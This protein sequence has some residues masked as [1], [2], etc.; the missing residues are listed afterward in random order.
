MIQTNDEKKKQGTELG[1]AGTEG[2]NAE[3]EMNR[4]YS[5]INSRKSFSY[6]PSSDPMYRSYARQYDMNGRMA[7]RNSM[8]QTA[9]LTGGY[10]S[11]YGAAVGQQQYDEYMRRLSDQLPELY[12][13][14]YQRYE[15][16]GKALR[17]NYDMAYQRYETDY[18]R[19][20]DALA[21]QQ[22]QEQQDYARRQDS[23]NNLTKLI[24]TAGY[25]P[26]DSELAGAGMTRAQAD[27]LRNRYLMDKGLLGGGSGGGGSWSG[28]SSKKKKEEE[29]TDEEAVLGSG[30]TVGTNTVKPVKRVKDADLRGAIWR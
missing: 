23:Y 2:Y 13:Y 25:Q 9:A 20:Q 8:G 14:A 22:R 11:S 10:G 4:L 27:A 28:S 18:S 17:D 1:G 19:R 3:G 6:D 30:K 26:T 15:N 24:S 5:A 12:K 7:M 21:E 29:N 16:E